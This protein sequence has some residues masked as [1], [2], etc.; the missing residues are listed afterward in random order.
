M[1]RGGEEVATLGP[2][3]WAGEIALISDTPADGERDRDAR[4]SSSSSSRAAR[5]RAVLRDSP[6]IAQKVLASV[7]A[8]LAADADLTQLASSTTIAVSPTTTISGAQRRGRQPP[9]VARAELAAGDRP[10]GD[11]RRRAPGDVGHED[12]DDRRDAVD[13]AGEDVLERVDA[14]QVVVDGQPEDGEQQD[15]LRG[16][17]VAAVDAGAEDA[18][19][20]RAPAVLVRLLVPALRASRRGAAAA[21]RA[22]AR[23][24]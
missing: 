24:R 21:R 1:T 11:Q 18:G 3:D 15:A 9:P 2:G 17:E 14:L 19:E 16:A 8:R 12:E 22:P 20:R 13:D 10:D 5:S 6:S 4:R 23:A 7:G